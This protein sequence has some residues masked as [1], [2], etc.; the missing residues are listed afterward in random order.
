MKCNKKPDIHRLCHKYFWLFYFING[1]F[2]LQQLP[3]SICLDI[4]TATH[5]I[6]DAFTSTG[7]PMWSVGVYCVRTFSVTG[8]ISWLIVNYWTWLIK[9]QKKE[10]PAC[11][12]NN[13]PNMEKVSCDMCVNEQ[14]KALKSHL[15]LL[16]WD[17][18]QGERGRERG[19]LKKH[20]P[21]HNI[22]ERVCKKLFRSLELFSRINQT[23]WCQFCTEATMQPMD[24][25]PLESGRMEWGEKGRKWEA[26][27]MTDELEQ[28]VREISQYK[29]LSKR[30]RKVVFVSTY[31]KARLSSPSSLKWSRTEKSQD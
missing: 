17:S 6:K 13:L 21:F 29:S 9:K 8:Q 24:K 25:V 12:T 30:Q 26:Q 3:C 10:S 4:F 7:V 15:L 28:E 14:N 19:R 2:V 23:F 18:Y 22:E 1:W 11:W 20:T 16:L 27:Q 5:F 31:R